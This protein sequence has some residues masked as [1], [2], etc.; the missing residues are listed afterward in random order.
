MRDAEHTIKQIIASLSMDGKSPEEIKPTDSLQL[1]LGMDSL[2]LIE[3]LIALEETLGIF[4]SDE[5]LLHQ[6]DWTQT[7]GSVA[8]FVGGKI[9]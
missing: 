1:D 3:L 4:F 8:E 5:D 6:E 7:V 9:G 2:A